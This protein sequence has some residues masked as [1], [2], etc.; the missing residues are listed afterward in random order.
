METT[1]RLW[2]ETVG[3]CRKYIEDIEAAV[4]AQSSVV[5]PV[6][7]SFPWIESFEGILKEYF[8]ITNPS[9]QYE[10]YSFEDSCSAWEFLRDNYCS[11]ERRLEFRKGVSNPGQFLAQTEGLTMNSRIIR[12]SG[13][14]ECK[15]NEWKNLIHDYT[16]AMKKDSMHASFILEVSLEQ[17]SNI[18]ATVA[19]LKVFD[20]TKYVSSYDAYTFSALIAAA[21][22]SLGQERAYYTD[23]AYQL[24]G[25]NIMAM[26]TLAQHPQELLKNPVDYT[27]PFIPELSDAMARKAV[28]KTQIRQIFPILEEFRVNIIDQYRKDLKALLLVANDL[29]QDTKDENE[30]EIGSI[31]FLNGKD[32]FID[33]VNY[34]RLEVAHD[35]R[36]NLAH[37][38]TVEYQQVKEILSWTF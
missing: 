4:R 9:R 16:K 11:N 32:H 18:N 23:L 28:W 13:I 33:Y 20:L 14:P 24:C 29:D 19:G 38:K 2:W 6:N 31:Y 30:L 10:E 26:E 8:T 12:I 5:I 25:N 1:D 3:S 7:Q 36:N 37:L 21:Q 27:L 17:G 35:A 15:I 22:P 34:Q